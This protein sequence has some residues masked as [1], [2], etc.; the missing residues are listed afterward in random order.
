MLPN[1]DPGN[2]RESRAHVLKLPERKDVLLETRFTYPKRIR[3]SVE[4]AEMKK[5]SLKF[6]QYGKREVDLCHMLVC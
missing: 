4:S 1:P 6:L 5:K 2:P 3:S